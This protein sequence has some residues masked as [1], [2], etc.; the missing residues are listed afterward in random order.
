MKLISSKSNK[1]KRVIKRSDVDKKPEKNIIDKTTSDITGNEKKP[2]LS[3]DKASINKT[4]NNER[5][6][7]QNKKS[8]GRWSTKKKILV[9]ASCF[10]G[11]MLVLGISTFAIVR[12]Q[13]QPMFDYFFK[14]DVSSLAE[15]PVMSERPSVVQ[16]PTQTGTSTIDLDSDDP[17]ALHAEDVEHEEVVLFERKDNFYTFLVLG[18]DADGNT[19]VIKIAGF[20]ANE[21]TLDIVSIPRDTI[22]NVP[23]NLRKVN[24][25]HAYARNNNRGQGVAS[26][27][28]VNETRAHFRNL[29]GFNFDHMI[30]ISMSSFPNIV[31]AIGGVEFNVPRSMSV[32]G[33]NVS[34]GTQRLNG[35]QAIV[36]MRDRNSHPD[37]DIGRAT[38]QQQ[39]LNTVMRQFLANKNNVRI[40]DMASI[41][42]RHTRTSIELT[43]LVWFGRRFIEMDSS[44]I[45][46]HMMPGEFESLRGN[47]YISVQTDP[48]I[49]LIN[50]TVSP[51]QQELTVENFSILTRGPDRRLYV[52]D[53][54]WLGD[55]SWGGS[56]TGSSNPQTTTP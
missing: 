17:D 51:I 26:E 40:D 5:S 22:V 45:N 34:R 46:F 56:G 33:V 10:I 39:F 48:W 29:L 27:A 53:G 23:W 30:T 15:Q 52:T 31:D 24:S 49:E 25:I 54:N 6:V 9:I 11:L 20:D 2:V 12:W 19:D 32:D 16:N 3:S 44:N 55:S 47:F 37:G 18:I 43:D 28:V 36:V 13:I 1:G 8:S 50:Q 21:L 38:T 14:P 41:F 42:L 7:K 35:R 4:Q